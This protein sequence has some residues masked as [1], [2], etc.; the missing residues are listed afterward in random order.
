MCASFAYQQLSLN[1]IKY[2]SF[3]LILHPPPHWPLG[4]EVYPQTHPHVR[5]AYE[6]IF[7]GNDKLQFIYRQL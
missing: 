2:I 5:N 7:E 6:E 3:Y 4:P 1:A